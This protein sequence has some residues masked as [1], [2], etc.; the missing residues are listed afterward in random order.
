MGGAIKKLVASRGVFSK[1][2]FM[3]QFTLLKSPLFSFLQQEDL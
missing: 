2:I 3:I 1:G